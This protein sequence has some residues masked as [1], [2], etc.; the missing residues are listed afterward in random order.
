MRNVL[1]RNCAPM[2]RES[3]G[4]K[5]GEGGVGGRAVYLDGGAQRALPAAG[6]ARACRRALRQR[7]EQH[8]A[9][10]THR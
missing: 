5:R 3:D 8:E 2:V 9:V 10:V 6:K 4:V 7:V 1:C